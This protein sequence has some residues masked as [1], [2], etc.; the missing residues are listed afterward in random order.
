MEHQCRG[1]EE[2]LQVLVRETQGATAKMSEQ[3]E[4]GE[5]LRKLQE[6]YRGKVLR[7]KALVEKTE[8]SLAGMKELIELEARLAELKR[9]ST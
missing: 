7:H 2:E 8:Q 9:T 1:L 3:G 5:R 6:Q 4:E